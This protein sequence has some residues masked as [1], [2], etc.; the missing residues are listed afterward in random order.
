MRNIETKILSEK[1]VLVL[2]SKKLA[3]IHH[4]K[5]QHLEL[6]SDL[7]CISFKQKSRT[8]LENIKELILPDLKILLGTDIAWQHSGKQ[9]DAELAMAA[10]SQAGGD[11]KK[12]VSS[13]D[14]AA[15]SSYPAAATNGLAASLAPAAVS[16]DAAALDLTNVL[17]WTHKKFR[18]PLTT[19]T[20]H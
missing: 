19:S 15:A 8:A 18:F 17:T 7:A 4:H 1:S 20:F 5:K 9:P 11:D 6:S 2:S 14:E 13:K 10:L 3:A 16:P 12:S